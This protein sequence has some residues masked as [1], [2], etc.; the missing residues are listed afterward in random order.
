M[1]K[2]LLNTICLAFLAPLSLSA[3]GFTP[4]YSD[5]PVTQTQNMRQALS[6]IEIPVIPEKTGQD[7]RNVLMDRLYTH[8]RPTSPTH[9]LTFTEIGESKVGLGITKDSSASR[10]Q[11]R[12]STTMRLI[13]LETNEEAL[14]RDLNAVTSYNIQDSHFTTLVSEKEARKNAVKE[15]AEKA[16]IQ[17]EISFSKD[18]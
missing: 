6:D 3:C 4:V 10:A 8:G 9:K 18:Q 17:L 5:K 1:K 12:L 14:K 2:T 11:L 7:L 13:N 15:L 16:V